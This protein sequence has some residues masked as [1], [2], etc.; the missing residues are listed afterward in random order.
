MNHVKPLVGALE[1]N[2][3]ISESSITDALNTKSSFNLIHLETLIKADIFVLKDTPYHQLSFQ[4]RIK[5]YLDEDKKDTEYFLATP[6]DMVLN[7]LAGYKLGGSV[8]DRQWNDLLGV[9]K[10]QKQNLDKE[11]LLKW[12]QELKISSLLKQAFADSGFEEKD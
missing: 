10:I 5:D 6:E 7:K 11:Y 3:Y 2:Y 9:L 4:R 1:A 8:S 12:A